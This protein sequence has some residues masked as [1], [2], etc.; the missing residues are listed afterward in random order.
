[1]AKTEYNNEL[2]S[3]YIYSGLNEEV[4]GSISAGDLIFDIG[5]SGKLVGVE[6]ENAS[7][8]LQLKPSKFEE[9]ERAKVGVE[10]RGNMIFLMFRFQLAPNIIIKQDFWL[11][12]PRLLKSQAISS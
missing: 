11:N 8:L 4:I 10:K 6:V 9:I 1:M 3:L 12:N 2:D 7:E 5:Q